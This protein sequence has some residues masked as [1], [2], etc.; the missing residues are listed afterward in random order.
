MKTIEQFKA[1]SLAEKAGL[2]LTS[3]M[4]TATICSVS[5][6]VTL[7]VL[8]LLG[9][10]PSE[11]DTMLY[12]LF[13]LGG[14]LGSI[15]ILVARLA[16]ERAKVAEKDLPKGSQVLKLLVVCLLL[17][18]NVACAHQ[19]PDAYARWVTEK[20]VKVTQY[21]YPDNR[22][23]ICVTDPRSEP[24]T[25]CMME[26]PDGTAVEVKEPRIK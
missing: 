12:L 4:V 19:Q 22:T 13:G 25:L 14:L 10:P 7:F 26:R 2:L 24:E 11:V 18:S 15:V 6:G 23:V 21:F 17:G 20:G 5:I 8:S 9:V 1:L 16:L 3:I